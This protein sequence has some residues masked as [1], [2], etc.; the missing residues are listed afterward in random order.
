MLQAL[1]GPVTGLLDRN[2][3]RGALCRHGTVQQQAPQLPIAQNRHR[4]ALFSHQS[5]GRMHFG[6][7]VGSFFK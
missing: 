1:I 2:L 7:G 3:A 5:K 4:R 6:D